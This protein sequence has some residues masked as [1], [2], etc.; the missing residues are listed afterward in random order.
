MLMVKRLSFLKNAKKIAGLKV[1][2]KIMSL[3]IRG[4]QGQILGTSLNSLCGFLL[5][6]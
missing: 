4:I 1:G 6:N 2:N 5:I 3:R